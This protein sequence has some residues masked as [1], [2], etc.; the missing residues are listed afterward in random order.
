MR[1]TVAL[2]IVEEDIICEENIFVVIG[3][4]KASHGWQ[5]AVTTFYSAHAASPPGILSSFDAGQLV[6]KGSF[7]TGNC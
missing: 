5:I 1:S 6:L 3:A 4:I 2:R 7:M